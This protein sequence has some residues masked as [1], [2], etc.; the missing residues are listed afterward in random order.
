MEYDC[1]PYIYPDGEGWYR[2]KLNRAGSSGYLVARNLGDKAVRPAV[3]PVRFTLGSRTIGE[4]APPIANP[5]DQKPGA[6]IPL[7]G[8]TMSGEYL[9]Y[10]VEHGPARVVGNTL[11][12]LPLPANTPG[13]LEVELVAY[14]LGESVTGKASVTFNVVR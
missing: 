3:Q 14:T 8:P 9:G 1:G 5:G 13:P 6:R 2:V 7:P 10:Y 4:G 12:I 11:E